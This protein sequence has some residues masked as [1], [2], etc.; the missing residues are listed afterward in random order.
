MDHDTDAGLIWINRSSDHGVCA[1][2]RLLS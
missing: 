1:G 2:F